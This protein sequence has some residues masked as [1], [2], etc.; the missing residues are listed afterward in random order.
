MVQDNRAG[1]Q[2][3]AG[4]HRCTLLAPY[5]YRPCVVASHQT[6]TISRSA[7]QTFE[8]K[9]LRETPGPTRSDFVQSDRLS[10]VLRRI[11]IP[12]LNCLTTEVHGAPVSA[13]NNKQDTANALSRLRIASIATFSTP[14]VPQDGGGRH[15]T[16]KRA[17]KCSKTHRAAECCRS[18]YL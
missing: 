1:C 2:L 14:V 15:P 18:V 5:D 3:I 13:L 8:C 7:A 9:S 6:K 17:A 10:K 12:R 11:S 4:D 16:S